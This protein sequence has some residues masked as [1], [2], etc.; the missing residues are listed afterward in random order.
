MADADPAREF[1][2]DKPMTLD[3]VAPA[4]SPPRRRWLRLALMFAIPILIAALGGYFY[5]ASGRY[6][7][8]DNAYVQQDMVSVSPDVS[9]RIV[10]VNVRENQR[11]KAGDVLFRIDPEPYRIALAQADADLATARVQVATMA[12]DTGS[13]AADIQ[14]ARAELTLAQATY[15]RQDALMKRGFTTRAS[16]DAAVQDVAA[17][18]AKIATAE[19]SAARARQ[20]LGSGGGT[21]Q[22]A[23]IQVA[24]AKREKAAFDLARTTVR[25]PKD[26]VVS[27][28]SR[29]Q[30]GNI[31]PSGVP[32]LSLV[33]SDAAWVEANFKETDLDHMR[34][35]QPAKLTLDAY[36][37]MTVRGRVQ[38]IGAGTGS[39]FSVLPAQNANGNWVKVTQRV[40]VRIAIEGKP[41][42]PLIA[43][44]S[45]DV[46]IDTGA[47]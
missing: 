3:P 7:S 13:A 18:R 14:S 40:P 16:F 31:T 43:G 20:Q 46:K 4:T 15:A 41:A 35:G 45:T 27:Q 24:L 33:V 11:V 17:A 2:A 34:V 47:R 25:A 9:G 37:G 44:L 28:T 5:L 19:A 8:T 12:T 39:E 21:G 1:V 23:A 32:A 22:P 6:I 38:S 36:P 29:L 30:I 42:R 10:A 26:G